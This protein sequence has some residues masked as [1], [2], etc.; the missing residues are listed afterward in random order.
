MKYLLIIAVSLSVF[1]TQNVFA[2][3]PERN[4]LAEQLLVE[5]NVEKTIEP[6]KEIMRKS[7]DAQI[8]MLQVPDGRREELKKL[9]QI[10]HDLILEEFS[11][12]NVKDDFEKLYA[13][14]FTEEELKGLLSF[15]RSPAGKAYVKKAPELGEK[16]ILISQ[17]I[18]QRIM[19]KLLVAIQD[20]KD[21]D[22]LQ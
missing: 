14:T 6:I 8:D 3:N 7:T 20:F 4:K 22:G 16:T 9:K 10:S 17:N 15:Y 13:E 1:V 11:W 21:K 5:M 12:E 19:P 18:A 2:E